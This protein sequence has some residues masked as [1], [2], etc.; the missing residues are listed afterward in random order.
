MG[1]IKNP[2][3]PTWTAVS[4]YLQPLQR[5]LRRERSEQEF[6]GNTEHNVPWSY[7]IEHERLS[8]KKYLEKLEMPGPTGR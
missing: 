1:Q 2:S 7:R 6:L 5:R 8:L 3:S 4:V